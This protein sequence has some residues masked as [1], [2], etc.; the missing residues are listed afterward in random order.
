MPPDLPPSETPPPA[1]KD[2]GKK[3]GKGAA[4]VAAESDELLQESETPNTVHH[5][6]LMRARGEIFKK[7]VERFKTN[8]EETMAYFDEQRLEE[9]KFQLNWCKVVSQLTNQ[10]YSTMEPPP[11]MSPSPAP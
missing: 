1:A 9:N 11:P 10:P 3:G 5:K 4:P 7:Y 8:V 6:A 2:A